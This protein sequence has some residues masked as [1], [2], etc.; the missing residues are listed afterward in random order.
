MEV[1][2]YRVSCCIR[3]GIGL[4]DSRLER[5]TANPRTNA[6]E[7][8][9][10]NVG[11]PLQQTTFCGWCQVFHRK[12][13]FCTGGR[14]RIRTCAARVERKTIK[15]ICSSSRTLLCNCL[16]VFN[17]LL[18][19]HLHIFNFCCV[20]SSC[21]ILIREILSTVPVNGA[22]NPKSRRKAAFV[23]VRIAYWLHGR[24]GRSGNGG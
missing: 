9:L 1:R 13:Q 3:K 11:Q 14:C 2:L 19:Y 10:G 17:F 7:E 18:R 21:A 6:G 22:E 24:C 12:C 15:T 4:D 8:L 20:L 5:K 23:L 16:N